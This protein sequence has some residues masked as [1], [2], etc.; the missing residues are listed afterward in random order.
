MVRRRFRCRK[1]G[2]RF[3]T[4]VFEPGEAESKRLPSGPV[5]CPECGSPDVERL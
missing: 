4:E 1:C 2:N 3:E 5:K